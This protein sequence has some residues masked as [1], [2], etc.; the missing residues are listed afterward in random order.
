MTVKKVAI[1]SP[2]DMGSNC[3]RAFAKAG[4]RIATCL[5]G[6]SERTRELAHLAGFEDLPS[7]EVVVAEADLILSILPPAMALGQAAA[8]ADAMIAAG[9]TPP[10]A[11]CNAISPKTTIAVGEEIARAGAPYIDAGIIGRAP[12][13]S[14]AATRFYVSGPDTSALETLDGAGISVRNLGTEVGRASAMKMAYAA[15]TKGRWTLQAAALLTAQRWNL[16]EPY[17]A[18]LEESQPATF[19]DMN[20]MVPRLPLDAGRWIGEMQEIAATFEQAGVSPGFHQGAMEIMELLARTS[21][22]EETRETVDESRTL[23]EALE[24]FAATLRAKSV[25]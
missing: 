18:E 16:S 3:G 1:L 12:Y 6:R 21:I 14:K 5:A 20:R 8:V 24:I 10:Y 9:A 13:K 19:A 23:E 25:G 7:L 11:D 4:F 15:I 22:A 17:L 2:G